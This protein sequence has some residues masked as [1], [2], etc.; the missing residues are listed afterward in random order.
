MRGKQQW[1]WSRSCLKH[2]RNSKSKDRDKYVNIGSNAALR[3]CGNAVLSVWKVRF[4]GSLFYDCVSCQS[5]EIDT[6]SLSIYCLWVL[7]YWICF[8]M[9]LHGDC[10]QLAT[11]GSLHNF[12]CFLTILSIV[13]I[14]TYNVNM[15]IFSKIV[16]S[17]SNNQGILCSSLLRLMLHTLSLMM[18]D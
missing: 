13:F 9:V 1:S 17:V 6:V 12:T 10:V 11:V 18:T 3:T 7:N 14:H 4:S 5:H 8:R 2:C 16:I 15:N